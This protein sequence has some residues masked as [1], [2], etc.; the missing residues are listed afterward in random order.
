MKVRITNTH[1]RYN[2]KLIKEGTVID[3]PQKE[4]EDHPSILIP[5]TDETQSVTKSKKKSK[6]K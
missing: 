1:F 2:G 4:V 6:G 3:L 5:V